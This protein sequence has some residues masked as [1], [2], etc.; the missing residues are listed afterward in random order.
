LGKYDSVLINRISIV[1]VGVKVSYFL[2]DIKRGK[3]VFIA[4]R[5][6]STSLCYLEKEF[7]RNKSKKKK[8]L[9]AIVK[10]PR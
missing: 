9:I 4:K 1:K 6:V 5:T 3:H 2:N 10:A 8:G 7:R